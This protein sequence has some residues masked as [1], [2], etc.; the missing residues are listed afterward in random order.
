MARADSPRN[1][2]L[3]LRLVMAVPVLGWMLRDALYGRPDAPAWAAVTTALLIVLAVAIW[4][5][6][7]LIT[8]YLALAA[9]GLAGLVVISRA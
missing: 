7:A 8:A 9:L 6:P 5:Y 3:P 2:P 4:G 1:A